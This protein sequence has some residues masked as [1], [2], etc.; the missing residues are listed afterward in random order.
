MHHYR[1]LCATHDTILE[2]CRCPSPDKPTRWVP[3]DKRCPH[4]RETEA[5]MPVENIRISR[6]SL[7][8]SLHAPSFEKL[9]E[10]VAE[11]ISSFG[12]DPSHFKVSIT[13]HEV[14]TPVGPG[15]LWQIEVEAEEEDR[16]W[17]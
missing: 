16:P 15:D 12:L 9:S 11:R 2:Q 3:C 13:A 1:V 8:F 10:L 17:P 4:Y 6:T 7:N 5:A 14:R